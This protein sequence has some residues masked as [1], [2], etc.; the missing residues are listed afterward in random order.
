MFTLKLFVGGKLQLSCPSSYERLRAQL[1]FI[2]QMIPE[3]TIPGRIA[4]L[5]ESDD[6]KVATLLG[7]WR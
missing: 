1:P 7:V 6:G 5:A 3:I 2:E 4:M